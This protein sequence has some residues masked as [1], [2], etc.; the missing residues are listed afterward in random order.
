MTA[1]DGERQ[2]TANTRRAGRALVVAIHAA[3]RVMKLYPPEHQ[4]V[5]KSLAELAAAA[6]ESRATDADLEV[7]VH[8]EFIF[9]NGTRLRLD[10]SNYSSFGRVLELFR[11]NGVGV[12]RVLREAAPREWFSLLTLLTTLGGSA[13]ADA[14][15]LARRLHAAGVDAFEVAA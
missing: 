11:S 4:A 10:L 1:D 6:A 5:Q 12:L 14:D 9:V 15:E 7:R 2:E 3:S 13:G 8:G